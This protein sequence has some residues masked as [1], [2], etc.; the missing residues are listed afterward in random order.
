[1]R[2]IEQQ[3]QPGQWRI[4]KLKWA[5]EPPP[6]LSL[7][8]GRAL[9]VQKERA[10]KGVKSWVPLTRGPSISSLCHC[11]STPILI[12][13]M[14]FYKVA[15]RRGDE[16]TNRS[17]CLASRREETCRFRTPAPT[18]TAAPSH[19]CVHT[20]THTHTH[21]YTHTCR[22]A[23]TGIRGKYQHVNNSCIAMHLRLECK[24]SIQQ[25][26]MEPCLTFWPFEC[27]LYL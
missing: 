20:H 24:S 17:G 22:Q 7:P 16:A 25:G 26:G 21:K 4:T 8:P 23:Y 6:P 9:W 3:E 15:V 10:E 2:Q 11:L 14:W 12:R 5:S 27:M 18:M 13:V 19:K 1:M